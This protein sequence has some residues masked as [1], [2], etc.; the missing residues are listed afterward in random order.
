VKRIMTDAHNEAREILTRSRDLLETV[1]RRLLEIE[2]MEG[3]QLRQLMGIPP[4]PPAEATETIPLPT[5][6]LR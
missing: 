5:D 4:P 6:E 1:T 2:V 3:D